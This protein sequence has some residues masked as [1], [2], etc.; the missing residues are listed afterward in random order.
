M[1]NSPICWD[2]LN[3]A[4]SLPKPT[5]S[6]SETT[7]TEVVNLW[8]QSF[9]CWRTR[10]STRKTSSCCA[11][12]TNVVKLTA[13]TVFTTNVSAAS[14]SRPGKSSKMFS[15]VCPLRHS[16]MTR[17][18]ACTEVFPPNLSQ[19]LNS[20]NWLVPLKFL[21]TDFCAIYCGLIRRRVS[22]VGAKMIAVFRIHSAR[23]SSNNS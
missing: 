7:S 9:C 3:M 6:S 10:S 1:V 22:Q 5:T 4:G 19:L 12:I 11:E 23:R 14:Q 13:F 18:F 16:L 20:S 15:T 21:R 8:R 2:C 17:F